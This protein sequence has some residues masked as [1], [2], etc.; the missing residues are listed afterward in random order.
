MGGRYVVLP[1]LVVSD[2]LQCLFMTMMLSQLK[3]RFI[4]QN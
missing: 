3:K 4:R 1:G 2:G